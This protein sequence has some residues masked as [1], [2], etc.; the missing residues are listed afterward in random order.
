[1]M[2]M[3]H[4]EAKQRQIAAQNNTTGRAVMATLPG[5]GKG[6]ARDIAGK[7]VGVGGRTVGEAATVAICIVSYR[8][9]VEIGLCFHA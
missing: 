6:A 4:E 9:P 7:A 1:M 5:Q 8:L 2:P 3:L